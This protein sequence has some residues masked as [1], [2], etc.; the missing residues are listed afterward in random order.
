MTGIE[1]KS[2]IEGEELRGLERGRRKVV[3]KE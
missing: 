3:L 1:R 2:G